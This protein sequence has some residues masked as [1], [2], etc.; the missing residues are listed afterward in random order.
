MSALQEPVYTGTLN[1]KPLRFFKTPRI[2]GP[3]LPW[4]SFDDLLVCCGWPRDMRR[5]F[6]A[7]LHGEWKSSV[8]TVAPGGAP[9]TIAPHWMAQGIIGAAIERGRLKPPAEIV[10]ARQAVK[11]WNAIGGSGTT[12]EQIASLVAAFHNTNG[13]GCDE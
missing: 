6:R 10:Y 5:E 3:E 4:H 7:Q 13:T 8:A 2:G 1:D 11:A 9:I 12:E